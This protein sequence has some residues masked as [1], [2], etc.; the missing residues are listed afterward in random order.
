MPFGKFWVPQMTTEKSFFVLLKGMRPCDSGITLRSVA[1]SSNLSGD[2][3]ATPRP[4]LN[5]EFGLSKAQTVNAVPHRGWLA[6]IKGKFS[7]TIRTVSLTPGIGTERRDTKVI[8]VI[9]LSFMS[10]R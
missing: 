5:D 1:Y 9:A 6:I 7:F 3:T 10:T 2:V 4:H 8:P